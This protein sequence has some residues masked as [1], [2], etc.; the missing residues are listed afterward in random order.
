MAMGITADYAYAQLSTYK[1]WI[2]DIITDTQKN[3]TDMDFDNANKWVEM[4][5]LVSDIVTECNNII[6]DMMEIRFEE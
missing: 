6:D 3:Y 5:E 4:G 1:R 2:E